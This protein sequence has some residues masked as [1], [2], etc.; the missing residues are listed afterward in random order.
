MSLLKAAKPLDV[1]VGQPTTKIM[2]KIMVQ[3]RDDDGINQL[4]DTTAICT[5]T[6]STVFVYPLHQ[7][8]LS[9]N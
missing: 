9:G 7:C 6:L 2:N 3:H 1:I 8:I 5:S 4:K